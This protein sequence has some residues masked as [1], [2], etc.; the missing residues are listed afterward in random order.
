VV[1]GAG[2]GMVLL[3]FFRLPFTQAYPRATPV[4]IDEFNARA[5]ERAANGQVI[6][7]GQR[8]SSFSH[9]GAADCSKS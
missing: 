2:L 8:C 4:F 3:G 6:G 7:H 9:F 5:L 1:N